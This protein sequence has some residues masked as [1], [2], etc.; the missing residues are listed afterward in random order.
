MDIASTI[1]HTLL[2]PE[3]TMNEIDT[4]CTEAQQFQFHSVCVHPYWVMRCVS[5]L[6]DTSVKVC[7]VIGFPFGCNTASTKAFET[8]GALAAGAKEFDMVINLGALKSE[9]WNVV[10]GDIASVVDAAE[11]HVVKVILETSLLT[12]AEKIRACQAAETAGAHFVKTSTGFNTGGATLDDISLMRTAVGDRLQV[13]ASGGIRD[14]A[15][16]QSFLAAGA[17]RIGTSHGAKI[18]RGQSGAGA[19]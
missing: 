8:A 16:L 15:A 3:A 4:L 1:D 10:E 5:Q 2:R 7:S 9:A 19:Y 18:L 12:E 6:K 14:L 17:T 13:K 11:G